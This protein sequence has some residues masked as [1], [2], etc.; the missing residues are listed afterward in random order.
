[1]SLIVGLDPDGE[2]K[3]AGYDGD[4]LKKR[5]LE[6][7]RR[8]QP[9]KFSQILMSI[10]RV[11]FEILMPKGK[12]MRGMDG[13]APRARMSGIVGGDGKSREH[14]VY[15]GFTTPGSQARV[16]WESYFPN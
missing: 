10:A 6:A 13:W 14:A 9:E 16:T 7:S 2:L 1:M 5:G 15:R 4:T 8:R 12:W 11:Y 3:T